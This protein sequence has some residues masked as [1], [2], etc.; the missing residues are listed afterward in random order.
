LQIEIHPYL[1]RPEL[2]KACKDRE[3]VIE[4][5][6]SI[7]QAKKMDDAKLVDIAKRVNKTP[8]QVLIRWSIQ[9]GKFEKAN[10]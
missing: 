5:Y 4:A 10:N 6:S 8:A 1:A 9:K 7:V 3:I 2:A